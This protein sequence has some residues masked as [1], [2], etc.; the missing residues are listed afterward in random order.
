[1]NA[2]ILTNNRTKLDILFNMLCLSYSE[3]HNNYTFLVALVYSYKETPY[4]RNRNL[5]E[6]VEVEAICRIKK[7]SSYSPDDVILA[8]YECTSSY[9]ADEKANVNDFKLTNIKNSNPSDVVKFTNFE[10]AIEETDFNSIN[11]TTPDFTLDE[12]LKY[13][14]FRIDDASKK[15]NSTGD[16]FNITF[17]GT[18]NKD[19]EIINKTAQL[20]MNEIK[21]DTMDC[22]FNTKENKTA[23]LSCYFN[24]EKYKIINSLTFK[25]V[26]IYDES[27][28]IY[29]TGMDEVIIY[30]GPEEDII[31]VQGKNIILFICIAAAVVIIISSS[32]LIYI[33]L[34]R[35]R[36]QTK[37]A[38][39]K[40]RRDIRNRAPKEKNDFNYN[41]DPKPIVYNERDPKSNEKFRIKTTEE[42]W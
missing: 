30:K 37:V 5:E 28:P 12:L 6:K 19:I 22:V 27:H 20:K 41:I 35:K 38:S 8:E 11:K 39:V 36:K 13:V 24:A 14:T 2:F 42:K 9:E 18:I 29:I 15:Q 21:N 34:I 16:K 25:T 17:N 33:F 10:E 26:E 7:S 1:M 32:L 40:H 3:I 4:F 31:K 23:N